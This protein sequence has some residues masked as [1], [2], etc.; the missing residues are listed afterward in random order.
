MRIPGVF[1]AGF[2][3]DRDATIGERDKGTKA[4]MQVAPL[5]IGKAPYP[6]DYIGE[7]Q[8]SWWVGAGVAALVVFLASGAWWVYGSGRRSRAIRDRI[9]TD[10]TTGSLNDLANQ[11]RDKPDFSGVSDSGP[12]PS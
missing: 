6:R 4:P 2:V 5:L 9:N 11:V 7:S 12:R 3:Y 10:H 1:L 8:T